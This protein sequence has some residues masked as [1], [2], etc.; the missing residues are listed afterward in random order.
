LVATVLGAAIVISA[1]VA[2]DWSLKRTA[3]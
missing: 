1:N 2:L 3:E